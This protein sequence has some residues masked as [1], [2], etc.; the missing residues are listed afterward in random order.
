MRHRKTVLVLGSGN[1]G[2]ARAFESASEYWRIIRVDNN[3]KFISVSHTRTLDILDWID[4]IDSIGPVEVVCASPDCRQYS[5]ARAEKVTAPDLSVPHAIRDIID[6]VK[7][8]WWIIE[9]VRGACQWFDDIYGKHAQSVGPFFFW[10]L[11]PWMDVTSRYK[12]QS[13]H[14]INRNLV[15]EGV[16]GYWEFNGIK[17]NKWDTVQR[18]EIPLVISQALYDAIEGFI[19]L[20][21][22]QDG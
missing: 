12:G 7:P 11:F 4:W 9:N 22:W 16:G 15:I 17:Y 2:F 6:Y 3:P 8:R 5:T 20:T 14:R 18:A 13:R 19:P 10:G 21:E 1:G